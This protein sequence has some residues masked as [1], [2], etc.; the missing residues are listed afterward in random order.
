MASAGWHLRA[1]NHVYL[2]DVPDYE[3]HAGCFGTATGNLMG[4]WDRHGFPDF[5]TGPTAGGEAP[6]TSQPPNR[7]IQAL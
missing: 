7:G 6:L 2:T 4:F 5:Y 1:A 3:W